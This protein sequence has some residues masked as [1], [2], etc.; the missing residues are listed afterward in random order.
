MEPVTSQQTP[1]IYTGTIKPTFTP[2]DRRRVY[3]EIHTSLD[4][5]SIEIVYLS[6]DY[7]TLLTRVGYKN[8]NDQF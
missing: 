8:G 2:S 1:S 3:V 5:N 7:S 6:L 4:R